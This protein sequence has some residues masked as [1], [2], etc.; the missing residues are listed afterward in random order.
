M[1]DLTYD[2]FN[3]RRQPRHLILTRAKL[4]MKKGAQEMENLIYKK[5]SP[6]HPRGKL[7]YAL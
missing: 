1:E 2:G 3:D 7:E 4:A 6:Y 5:E